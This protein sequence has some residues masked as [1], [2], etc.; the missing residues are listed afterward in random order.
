MKLN[1]ITCLNYE[2]R[3]GESRGHTASTY[4]DEI[5]ALSGG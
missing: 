5:K 4:L 1:D 2:V 3:I